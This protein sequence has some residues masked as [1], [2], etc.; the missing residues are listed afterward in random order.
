MVVI[1]NTFHYQCLNWKLPHGNCF[2][3]MTSLFPVERVEEILFI[4]CKIWHVKWGLA[5][6][7]RDDIST[8]VEGKDLQVLMGEATNARL[9]VA[10]TMAMGSKSQRGMQIEMFLF[11]LSPVSPSYVPSPAGTKRVCIC[12][13]PS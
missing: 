3:L 13:L 12:R 6:K 2:I 8:A 10:L 9:A 7:Q 4:V 1:G 11:C 5:G